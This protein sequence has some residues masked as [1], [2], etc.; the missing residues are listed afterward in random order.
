MQIVILLSLL[1]L[2]IMLVIRTI[3]LKIKPDAEFK[4]SDKKVSVVRSI[5]TFAMKQLAMLFYLYVVAVGMYIFINRIYH[6]HIY[7]ANIADI[8]QQLAF[9]ETMQANEVVMK[10][11]MIV[12]TV[13]VAGVLPYRIIKLYDAI[14]HK[15]N[16][17]DVVHHFI[18]NTVDK[19]NKLVTGQSKQ[20][21][22]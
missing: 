10:L 1:I 17:K 13:Y 12:L 8:H 11:Y 3:K 14:I 18:V 22:Q 16:S 7:P 4:S 5:A 6:H 20:N 19:M 15:N 21:G 2:G 9:V